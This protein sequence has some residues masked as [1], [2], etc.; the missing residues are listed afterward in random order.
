MATIYRSVTVHLSAEDLWTRVADVGQISDLLDIVHK[1]SV[2]GDTRSCTLADGGQLT[3]T[4]V[5]IDEEHQRVAYTITDSPFP[6]EFHAASM[7]VIDE[8]NGTST[9]VWITDVKPDAMADGLAP[10][11]EVNLDALGRRFGG[12]HCIQARH[13]P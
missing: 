2:S 7:Q 13:A 9:L 3:E 12:Q 6:I 10:M 11:I 4:I 8:G 1:S 5:G